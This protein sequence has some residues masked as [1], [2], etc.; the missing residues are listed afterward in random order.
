MADR[1]PVAVL[2]ATGI[3]G[4]YLV[5]I[6]DKHP[7]FEVVSVAASPRSAGKRYRDIVKWYVGG[8]VPDSVADLTVVNIRPEEVLR[9]EVELVFSALPSEVARE[10]EP[11]FAS[12]GIPVFSDAGA[13]RREP[14]VPVMIAEVNPEHLELVKLQRRRGWKAFIATNPNCTAV[15]MCMSL[16]PLDDEFGVE[17]VIMVSM[18]AI[19]GAGYTGL[20]SMAIF[21]NVIPYISREEEKVEWE[22]LK[23]FGKIEDGRLVHADFTVSTS[24][25]RVYVYDGHTEC[26]FVKLG[27][28]VEP[29]EVVEAFRNF[30]GLPQELKLPTAPEKPIVYRDEVDRPQPRLDRW[31]GDGMSV[32]VGRVRRDAA[33]GGVKYVALGHNLIRGAAGN[34]ILTA[35]LAYKLGYL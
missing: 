35:E 14:D 17:R 1:I 22:T 10:V 26:I 23:I 30:R 9:E 7:W 13:F 32:V 4:Q 24:C 2:G 15:A 29:E 21:D 34:I 19:S 6:I 3:V 25:N 8:E 33:L 11:E 28:D 20:P 12:R 18:Q 31:A 5:K 16:K 27:R